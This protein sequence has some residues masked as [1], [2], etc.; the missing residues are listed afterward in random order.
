MLLVLGVTDV[1]AGRLE[2]EEEYGVKM[3]SKEKTI[4]NTRTNSSQV[5]SY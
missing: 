4:G 5:R 1:G 3:A 2:F